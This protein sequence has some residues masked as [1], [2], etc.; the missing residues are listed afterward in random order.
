MPKVDLF[1]LKKEIQGRPQRKRPLYW[2]YGGESWL[3]RQ[4]VQ[5][6][7][8]WVLGDPIESQARSALNEERLDAADLGTAHAVVDLLAAPSLFG[9]SRLIV[10]QDAHQLSDLEVLLDVP[11]DLPSVAILISKEW[12]QRKKFSKAF[13]E[14][15]LVVACEDIPEAERESWVQKW[16]SARGLSLDRELIQTLVFLEPWSLDRVHLEIE[17]LQLLGLDVSL[18]ALQEVT[19]PVRAEKFVENFLLRQKA[20]TWGALLELSASPE[21]ALPMMGLLAWNLRHLALAIHDREQGSRNLKVS[22]FIAEKINRY[23]RHW[24]LSDAIRAQTFLA[25]MDFESKQ[26]PKHSLGVWGSMVLE[27]CR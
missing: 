4:A 21:E 12:D 23:A 24:K 1:Q 6:I 3:V 27:F 13:V 11:M 2:I 10:I 7:R 9:G 26:T 8:G 14:H 22:P 25:E 15:G 19:A 18:D 20:S 17:K 16:V 5:A